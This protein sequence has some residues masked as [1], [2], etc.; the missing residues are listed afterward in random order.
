MKANKLI[1]IIDRFRKKRIAVIGDLMLD[2]YLWGRATRISPEAPVPVVSIDRT[3][4]CLGGAANV[5]RNLVTLG[6]S[7]LAFGMIGDDADGR[8]LCR[9]LAEYGINP[10]SVCVDPM[11]QTTHKQ[12]VIAGTQQLLRVDHED[13]S[14]APVRLREAITEKVLALIEAGEVDAVIFEDYAK[15]LLSDEM[16]AAIVPAAARRGIITALDPKPGNLSPVRGLTVIKPNRQEAVAMAALP[17]GNTS[18][19]ELDGVAARLQQQWEPEYLLISLAAEGMALYDRKGMK[20]VIPTRAR[21]VFDVSGAGDTVV[22]AF[23]L[24]LAAGAAPAEAA[25]IGN[26]AAGIVV[27]KVG[28]V[29]VAA[30]EVKKELNREN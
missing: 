5:M 9:Q 11:R 1:S 28:T 15:G 13:A 29:P 27:G 3:S 10:E 23:T 21:E 17:P 8:E 16:L 18:E 2:V 20:T 7:A 19:T 26:Y 6:G 4:S 30:D 22:A 25:E 14:P 24:A 12:R